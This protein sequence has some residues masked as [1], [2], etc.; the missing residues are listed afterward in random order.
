MFVGI[1]VAILFLVEQY[2]ILLLSNKVALSRQSVN[3][4]LFICELVASNWTI[5]SFHFS[6][7]SLTNLLMRKSINICWQF[8]D[9][10]LSWEVPPLNNLTMLHSIHIITKIIKVEIDNIQGNNKCRLCGDKDKTVK[11]VI[12]ESNKLT[13]QEYKNSHNLFGEGD[14][15]VIVQESKIL[16]YLQMVYALTINCSFK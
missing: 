10:W 6:H 12:S 7:L 2:K 13:K 11:H 16:R 14:P 9:S 3:L 1:W 4:P 8:I 15:L 5:N